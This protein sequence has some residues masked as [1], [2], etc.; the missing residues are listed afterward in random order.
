MTLLLLLLLLGMTECNNR[1]IVVSCIVPV[2]CVAIITINN[3]CYCHLNFECEILV[4]MVVVYKSLLPA[5][6][7]HHSKREFE[8][9]VPMDIVPINVTSNISTNMLHG[10]KK[11]NMIVDVVSKESSSHNCLECNRHDKADAY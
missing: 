9:T 11:I 6:C 3:R 8:I 10:R 2:V 1:W 4:T 5:I 7:H